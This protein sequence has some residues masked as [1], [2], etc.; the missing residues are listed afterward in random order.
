MITVV[1][2]ITQLELG[3]AQENTL[4]TCGHL[5]RTEFRVVLA[6]GPGGILDGEAKRLPCTTIAPLPHLVRELDPL[7][8][9]RCLM[10]LVKLFR[11]EN[12]GGHHV[13]VHTHSSKAGILGRL[14][15]RIARMIDQLERAADAPPR[16][17]PRP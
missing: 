16:K 3:G 14:A 9:S 5:D 12:R 11:A 2:V 4:Y 7:N 8:D 17:P 1:H 10:D 6:Y 13:I 15:A